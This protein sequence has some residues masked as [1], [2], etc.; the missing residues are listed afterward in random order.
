MGRLAIRFGIPIRFVLTVSGLV[1][2][3]CLTL[4]IFFVHYQRRLAQ[5]V[6]TSQGMELA[7]ILATEAQM[8]LCVSNPKGFQ[9]LV[10]RFVQGKNVVYCAI[11]DSQGR[12]IAEAKSPAY[13]SKAG[14][15]ATFTHPI[16][17]PRTAVSDASKVTGTARVDLSTS[18][19]TDRLAS[20]KRTTG[21]LALLV[22]AVGIIVTLLVVQVTIKP[23]RILLDAT[24]RIARGELAEPVQPVSGGEIRDLS[25][26]LNQMAFR[27]QQSHSQLEEYSKTLE[28]KVEHRTEELKKHVKDLSDSR[29]ATLNILEDVKEAKT[30]L[31]RANQD[32]LELDE[33]K[34]KFIGT[35]SHELKTPFTAVKANIDFILSGKEGEVPQNLKPYLLTI[36]RN[37]NRVQK[38]MEDFL[39][40]AQI[41]SGRRRLEPEEF[42]LGKAVREY[43]A[44]M[45]PI[46]NKFRI[47]VDIP[48]N[49]SV[50]GDPNR[51]HDVYINLL[52]NA[53]KFS[54]EGGE[55][56]I[57]AR[58]SDGETLSEV[59]DQGMGIPPEKLDHIFDEFFQ[60][61]RKKYGG[62]GLGLAIVKGIIQ[63]HGGRIWV[64]SRPG[65]GSTFFFTLP[66]SKDSTHEP[67]ET[68]GEGSD[69]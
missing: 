22:L 28:K 17:G 53:L 58:L 30:E 34:S 8:P 59:S 64:D 25:E 16:P 5:E 2:L 35:I 33:M 60:I 20:L 57:S 40:V 42:K 45:G 9:S 62:T 6:V 27:L 49:I 50:F 7:R 26:A 61:D 63:E 65:E 56:R 68:P 19:W 1:V 69:C 13:P 14:R 46:G 18:L 32:L 31:E 23:I 67:I 38:I 37:T 3:A 41:H 4:S 29:L 36:Q 10:E 48:N 47:T 12:I 15:I 66:P 51:L 44:E 39:D 54:P 52:S 11:R 24:Q 21:L 55:I 43:L